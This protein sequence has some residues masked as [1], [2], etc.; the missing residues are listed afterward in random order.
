MA[1]GDT[2]NVIVKR[3][4]DL[5]QF[6]ASEMV[7]S[8]LK[9]AADHT[10]LATTDP[11]KYLDGTQ[12]K[13][14]IKGYRTQVVL[15]SAEVLALKTTRKLAIAKTGVSNEIIIIDDWFVKPVNGTTDYVLQ[16]PNS[17]RYIYLGYDAGAGTTVS[18]GVAKY[19]DT[20]AFLHA[21]SVNSIMQSKPDPNFSGLIYTA[22]KDVYL[23][24]VGDDAL[25]LITGDYDYVFQ[26]DWHIETLADFTY[27]AP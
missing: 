10:D 14:A 15:T 13:N 5:T 25:E 12:L 4:R 7:L 17:V 22:N 1:I 3:E 21:T 8:K 6:S 27:T 18:G 2:P 16:A 20:D 24:V 23:D 26:I 9:I 11:Q 19:F